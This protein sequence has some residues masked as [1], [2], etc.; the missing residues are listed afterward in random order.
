MLHNLVRMSCGRITASH[1]AITYFVERG[2]ADSRHKYVAELRGYVQEGTDEDIEL[3]QDIFD[4]VMGSVDIF[5]VAVQG[6][7]IENFTGAL[8]LRQ[9]ERATFQRYGFDIRHSD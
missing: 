8:R 3:M 6:Q 7:V 1:H 4:D 2:G 9:G 5:G